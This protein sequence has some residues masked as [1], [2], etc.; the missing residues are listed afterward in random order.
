MLE[1]ET[2][3]KQIPL[4]EGD[5]PFIFISY[6]HRDT[7]DMLEI[8]RLLRAKGFRFWYDDGLHSGDDWNLIIAKH[9][10]KA[11]VCLLILSEDA[12]SSVYVKN[13]LNFAI[14][15]RIPIHTIVLHSFD[16]PLDIEMML[17]RLQ[18]V[19]KKPGYEQRLL[20]ALPSELYEETKAKHGNEGQEYAHPLFEVKSESFNRQGTVSYLGIHRTLGYDVLIQKEQVGNVGSESLREQMRL[21]GRISHPL[22]PRV[23]DIVL[24]N[25]SMYTY[26]EYR[27]EEFLD[28]YLS[29]HTLSED[30]IVEWCNTV[31]DGMDYL[32]SRNLGVRE[33][34]RGSTV[35]CDGKRIGIFRLQN[36]HYG[37]IKLNQETRQ[38][39]FESEAQE[40]GILLYQLCTREVPILPLRMI[41]SNEYSK[42]FLDKVNLIIQKSVRENHRS[43]YSSFVEMKTDLN[44]SHIQWND[45]RFLKA[46]GEKLK[47]YD[48]IKK[49]NIERMYADGAEVASRTISLEEEFGFDATVV[50]PGEF[51]RSDDPTRIEL[52]ICSTRQILKFT[53]DEVIIGRSQD[54]DMVLTQPS[55]SRR[56]TKIL[57]SAD[58]TFFVQDLNSSNGTFINRKNGQ[59][60]KQDGVVPISKGDIISV[61]G[62][63]I[64]LR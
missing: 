38:Y 56:H 63:D 15:H 6:S 42:P 19:D 36:P 39:Y 29:S 61:G 60:I 54:C 33:F 10:E 48:V 32:Y 17:G 3:K 4:Y 11:S 41:S 51:V 31:I 59:A 40:I 28:S 20:E 12:A 34:A 62:V 1:T 16:M 43:Q 24:A 18:M 50:L 22:F 26:Q 45:K 37:V 25:N 5:A 55:V 44:M 7:S 57:R 14:K 8:S 53:K 13:E 64:L 52:Q 30:D 23:L 58:N 49:E 21:I 9:I 46:R 2:A 27:N 35:V 47:Q